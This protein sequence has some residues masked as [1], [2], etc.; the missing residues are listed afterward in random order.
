MFE[1]KNDKI[2]ITIRIDEDIHQAL[3]MISSSEMR[4]LNTQIEYMLRNSVLEYFGEL[5][6][7]PSSKLQTLIKRIAKS[8]VTTSVP[9]D[10]DEE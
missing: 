10:E 1:L 5:S 3:K 4:S 6:M 7:V 9:E 8:V 2:P